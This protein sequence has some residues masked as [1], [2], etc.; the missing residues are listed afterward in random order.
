M[1][2]KTPSFLLRRHLFRPIVFFRLLLQLFWLLPVFYISFTSHIFLNGTYGW[3]SA[4]DLYPMLISIFTSAVIVF[5]CTPAKVRVEKI[6]FVINFLLYFVFCFVCYVIF[7]NI[8]YVPIYIISWFFTFLFFVWFIQCIVSFQSCVLL[9][10]ALALS[11][12]GLLVRFVKTRPDLFLPNLIGRLFDHGLIVDSMEWKWLI[13]L[14]ILDVT[15]AYSMTYHVFPSRLKLF[16]LA[17]EDP[18]V[19]MVAESIV[20]QVKDDGF[21]VRAFEKAYACYKNEDNSVFSD[22]SWMEN[23]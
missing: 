9:E 23:L 8:E 21:F 5:F 10:N 17:H 19:S 20:D 3:T 16:L 11:T 15:R 4:T 18:V 22:Q 12:P 14:P 13:K 6:T 2:T 7:F 1:I